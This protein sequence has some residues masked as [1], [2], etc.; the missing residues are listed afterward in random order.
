MNKLIIL[1]L[2]V[3]VALG[4]PSC[5]KDDPVKYGVD[6]K[7]P[8][9]KA[10]D[11]GTVVNG[12][13]VKWASF[14][15]GASREWQS[16][17]YYAWGESDTKLDYTWAEYKWTN[18]NLTRYCPLEKPSCW[19]E[20]TP[21]GL[22]TLLPEDDA[23]QVKL[24]GKWRMPTKD[25]LEALAGLK[26]NPD[27]TWVDYSL[28][29]DDNGKTALNA[30]GKPVYGVRITRLSTGASLFL[31]YSGFFDGTDYYDG[32]AVGYCW[33]SSLDTS[34]PFQAFYLHIFSTPSC[35]HSFERCR[36]L[37]IRPVWEE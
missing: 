25:E 18:L 5:K 4:V 19:N 26:D 29:K 28:A 15:L 30:E 17:D 12:R 10:V 35:S 13:N 31:P 2:T 1:S 32:N 27:Y 7:T 16:G 22:R 6:G 36:G 33:S 14:N 23:A 21:D 11:L 3:L 37:P 8:L 34:D 20:G 9:P 24:G